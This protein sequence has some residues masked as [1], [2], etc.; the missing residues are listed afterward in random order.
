MN[1]TT[2]IEEAPAR[3]S[4]NNAAVSLLMSYLKWATFWLLIG[5]AYGLLASIKL[6]WPDA[7]NYSLLSFGRIRPI[8]TNLVF[9][10][11]SSMA[12]LGLAF[13]IVA[14]TSRTAL[15]RPG[16]AWLCWSEL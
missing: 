2:G 13:Y 4:A 16:L 11:W 7:A 9:L 8:H 1:Q 10:G 3:T 14:R 12:L 6:F 5:T 15:H